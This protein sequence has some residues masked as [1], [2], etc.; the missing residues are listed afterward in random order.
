MA[1]S[2]DQIRRALQ[3]QASG[4]E[5]PT[6][7]E[8]DY[9]V[10]KTDYE[11]RYTLGVMY[12]P[13]ALDSDDEYADADELQKACWDF[14]RKGQRRIRDTH[15]KQ[16]IGEL[17]ELVSWPFTIEAPVT[18]P[19]GDVRKVKL[20]EGTVFAGVIWD[21]DAWQLVKRGKLRGYSM[22]GRAVR[23]K[24]AAIDESLPRMRDLLVEAELEKEA[25]NWVEAVGGMPKYI[26]DI[27]KHVLSWQKAVGIVQRWCRGG[28]NVTA[29]TRAKACKAVAQWE[30]MKAKAHAMS[31]VKSADNPFEFEPLSDPELDEAEGLIPAVVLAEL[32]EED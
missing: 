25:D 3:K 32:L 16:E 31:A 22:G 19:G 21:D 2:F 27:H 23:L 6:S 7:D 9:S 5:Q 18:L 4:P 13:G 15:T 1:Q 20:P 29:K 14:V 28:G 26:R 11:H 24:Q 12:V 10:T 30:K 8:V 17:V